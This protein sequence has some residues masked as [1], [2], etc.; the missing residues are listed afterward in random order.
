M[1]FLTPFGGGSKNKKGAAAVVADGSGYDDGA[2]TEE[3]PLVAA[4]A[5][6]T[7]QRQLRPLPQKAVSLS[8]AGG[9]NL[10]RVWSHG[11][12]VPA[13]AALLLPPQQ[14]LKQ[15]RQRGVDGGDD[16]RESEEKR[17]P[18]V[19]KAS[20]EDNNNNNNKSK[21]K[22]VVIYYLIYALVRYKQRR[23]SFSLFRLLSR[24]TN[25]M[26]LLFASVCQKT[27]QKQQVNVIISVPGLYGYAAVIF[28]HPVFQNHMNALSKLVIFSSLVHQLSFTL[29]STMPFAIG[30]VQDAGLIFLSSMA[31]SIA[32]KLLHEADDDA[33]AMRKKGGH[34]GDDSSASSADDDARVEAVIL[35]TT[36]VLLSAGTA[37]LGLVL[38]VIG[39]CKVANLVSYLPMPVVGGAYAFFYF[40]WR[41]RFFHYDISN[42]KCIF[43]ITCRVLGFYRVLLHPSRD[44]VVHI[45]T[46]DYIFRLAVRR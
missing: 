15:Q 31:N 13:A 29:F 4:A 20:A 33:A 7:Q 36:M 10:R 27:T 45:S 28:N 16:D 12:A 41:S 9:G 14:Q 17:I 8:P 21:S 18:Y 35:S 46:V 43:T 39:K 44:G 2:S 40:Q 24:L 34:G 5:G 38:I 32:E 23:T 19:R 25:R 37:L 1:S 6:G 11:E 3:T 26:P 42:P 22:A 30:T